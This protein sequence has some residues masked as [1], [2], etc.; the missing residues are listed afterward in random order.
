MLR[1]FEVMHYDENDLSAAGTEGL[2][3]KIEQN[4][5]EW[6]FQSGAVQLELKYS[7]RS[8]KQ[9]LYDSTLYSSAVFISIILYK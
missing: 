7:A 5:D 3:N 9:L 8:I 2:K 1:V 6:I 4:I